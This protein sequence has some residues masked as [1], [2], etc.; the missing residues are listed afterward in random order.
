MRLVILHILLI[1]SKF[2]APFFGGQIEA[3]FSRAPTESSY[4]SPFLEFRNSAEA[5]EKTIRFAVKFYIWDMIFRIFGLATTIC[6]A[7]KWRGIAA[8]ATEMEC[9]KPNF[10]A[11]GEEFRKSI[12]YKL[13]TLDR[14]MFT[15]IFKFVSPSATNFGLQ[16]ATKWTKN[17]VANNAVGL[18]KV[19]VLYQ[20]ALRG[21][22]KSEYVSGVGVQK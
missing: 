15:Q 9:G 10:L 1:D 5:F 8:A 20:N 19:R 17:A 13:W 6:E 2:L 16:L 21:M 22:K 3:N 7:P 14:R 4:R 12:Q 18:P 11:T